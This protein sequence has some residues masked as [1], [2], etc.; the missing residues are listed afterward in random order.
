MHSLAFAEPLCLRGLAD[1][2][3]FLPCCFCPS[4][5][6][7][8][9]SSRQHEPLLSAGAGCGPASSARA[10]PPDRLALQTFPN[11]FQFQG[12]PQLAWINFA[13]ILSLFFVSW[14]NPEM[15]TLDTVIY[16]CWYLWTRPFATLLHIL[17]ASPLSCP[18]HSSGR[19]PPDQQQRSLL[20]S[21]G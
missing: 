5:V 10:F 7:R 4:D 20:S 15:L 16:D 1:H 13:D 11:P 8:L 17:C 21:L 6:G 2:R 19:W 14:K 9:S 12:L 3:A 18:F